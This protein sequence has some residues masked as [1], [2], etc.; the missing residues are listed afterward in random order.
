MEKGLQLQEL[1]CFTYAKYYTK[2]LQIP[3]L[4]G[5]NCSLP[6]RFLPMKTSPPDNKTRSIWFLASHKPNTWTDSYWLVGKREQ[7]I[8]AKLSAHQD[9]R[10]ALLQKQTSFPSMN[11]RRAPVEVGTR[12]RSPCLSCSERFSRILPP[13]D[14]LLVAERQLVHSTRRTQPISLPELSVLNIYTWTFKEKS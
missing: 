5:R 3:G 11:Q 1:C 10:A 6:A 12:A 13:G 4:G 2:S 7:L 8:P 14:Q 9:L